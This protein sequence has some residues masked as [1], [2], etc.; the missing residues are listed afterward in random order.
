MTYMTYT[1]I[2]RKIADELG[3]GSTE[4][5]VTSVNFYTSMPQTDSETSP[6]V[7]S[8][9][10]SSSVPPITPPGVPSEVS[11]PAYTPLKAATDEGASEPAYAEPVMLVESAVSVPSAVDV[12]HYAEVK[13]SQNSQVHIVSVSVCVCVYVCVCV[14]VCVCACVRVTA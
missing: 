9:P 8:P 7:T 11:P 4:G 13:N 6:L 10:V 3:K 14:H 12:V 2:C 5:H 1:C